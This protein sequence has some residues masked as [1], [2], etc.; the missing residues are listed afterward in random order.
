MTKIV[1]VAAMSEGRARRRMPLRR[2]LLSHAGRQ[3]ACA[4]RSENQRSGAKF[5]KLAGRSSLGMNGLCDRGS[6]GGYAARALGLDCASGQRGHARR[7]PLP[8]WCRLYRARIAPTVEN[9][10]AVRGAWISAQGS[11]ACARIPDDHPEYA[12][13]PARRHLLR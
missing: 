12:G 4:N 5:C 8:L 1:P 13:G 7:H 3:R 11:N 6:P 9:H 2:F 10:I